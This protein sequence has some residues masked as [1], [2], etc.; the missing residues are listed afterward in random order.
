[1]VSLV[2]LP[3]Q[4]LLEVSNHLD[5]S[6]KSRLSQTCKYLYDIVT[7]EVYRDLTVNMFYHPSAAN[8]VKSLSITPSKEKG[9]RR[10]ESPLHAFDDHGRYVRTL[11]VRISR[12]SKEWT[13]TQARKSRVSMRWLKEAILKCR[14]LRTLRLESG[15]GVDSAELQETIYQPYEM[16]YP[17]L[18]IAE[19]IALSL[20]HL[21]E[22]VISGLS[23]VESFKKHLIAAG[24]PCDLTLS[25]LSTIRFKVEERNFGERIARWAQ[26]SDALSGIGTT[27]Q[28][29]NIDPASRR[30]RDAH[31]DLPQL[32]SW[33][34]MVERVNCTMGAISPDLTLS[35]DPKDE[36]AP[37]VISRT[38]RFRGLKQLWIAQYQPGPGSPIPW[39]ENFPG[40]FKSL[41]N[42]EGITYRQFFRDS[43]KRHKNEW[44]MIETRYKTDRIEGT[45]AQYGSVRDEFYKI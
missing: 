27:I 10:V 36:F 2:S 14:G 30:R 5:E 35:F 38:T 26:I 28:V 7:P 22:M 37:G 44:R 12:M 41:P 6:S 13:K 21:E 29:G 1:M 43:D 24:G 15:S 39:E 34:R 8:D 17:L 33:E 16:F 25:A 4:M 3:M 45:V 20:N 9:G 11:T 42:L 18:G 23:D 31:P 32:D 19:T 40:L